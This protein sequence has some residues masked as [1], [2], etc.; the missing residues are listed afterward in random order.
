MR[1]ENYHLFYP[2]LS[3]PI[4][5]VP[6]RLKLD[7]IAVAQ[8]PQPRPANGLSPPNSHR[9]DLLKRTASG[10]AVVTLSAT[11]MRPAHH[12]ACRGDFEHK[13]CAAGELLHSPP[14]LGRRRK[15]RVS[16]AGLAPT[17]GEVVT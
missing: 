11:A 3:K 16:A 7:I 17:S 15:P 1:L 10:A 14:I 13:Q 2:Q 12:L 4:L 6:T 8:P 9:A 5:S